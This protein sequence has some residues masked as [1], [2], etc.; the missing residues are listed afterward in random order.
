MPSNCGAQDTS[1][2]ECHHVTIGLIM[3]KRKNGSESD[4][5]FGNDV[6]ELFKQSRKVKHSEK[7]KHWQFQSRILLLL[8]M[9]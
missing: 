6:A 7:P 9:V 5:K 3:T 4:G 8:K 1:C 2:K